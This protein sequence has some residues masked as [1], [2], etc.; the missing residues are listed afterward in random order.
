MKKTGYFLSFVFQ[1]N[2]LRSFYF[3]ALKARR[4]NVARFNLT[5]LND[6]DFLNVST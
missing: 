1:K 6:S 2:L 4:A 3:S 5:V